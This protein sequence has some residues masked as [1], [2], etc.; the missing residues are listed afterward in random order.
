HVG[1]HLEGVRLAGAGICK[2]AGRHQPWTDGCGEVLALGRTQAHRRLVSLQVARR[3]VVEDQ[4]ATDR[5]V[6][7]VG[8]QVD[9]RGVDQRPDL[10]LVVELLAPSRR[11]DRV[12][13]STDLADV[14]EVEDRQ[15]VPG[16][17]NGGAASLPD[18]L[19]M[20]F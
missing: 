20:T 9:G 13:W 6:G 15:P 18:R 1:G 7:A 19:Y 2:F 4:V 12:A 16:L 3:P 8:F 14:A 10:E 5:L 11:P 17:R